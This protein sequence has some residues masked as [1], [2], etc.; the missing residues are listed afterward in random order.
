MRYI[1]LTGQ[2]SNRM[3]QFG[4]PFPQ[5]NIEEKHG[6][7]E[8]FGEFSYTAIEGL[9]GLCG[10]YV[11][12]PAHYL[13]YENSYLIDDVPLEKLV[14]LDCVVLNV[15]NPGKDGAGRMV[16]DL[17]DLLACGNA[18]AIRPGDALLVGVG[19]GDE[20]WFS[21][22]H[23]PCSPYFTYEAFMWLLEKSPCVIG[24]DTSS[25][26]NLSSPA[27]F[28]DAFYKQDILMLAGLRNL[29]A[30]TAP[31]VKLSI[32]PLRVENSCASP[33]RAFAVQE[34]G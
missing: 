6:F 17:P 12:T 34:G 18:E 11:E 31:R 23:F 9:H 19:W 15:R 3:W 21:Q 20:K 29:A 26:E 30:V 16:V 32:L 14:N 28:F 27:G 4:P 7:K 24:T 10:T 25:W 1:D 5:L 13:G 2:L 33:C 22:E 8:G